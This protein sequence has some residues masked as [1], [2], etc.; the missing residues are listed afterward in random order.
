MDGFGAICAQ[1]AVVRREA[2]EL[3]TAADV[4]EEMCASSILWMLWRRSSAQCA[5]RICLVG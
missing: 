4:G 1:L 2:G 5:S 3:L